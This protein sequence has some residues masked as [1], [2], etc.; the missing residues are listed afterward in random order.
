MV[1]VLDASLLAGLVLATQSVGLTAET[2]SIVIDGT[3]DLESSFIANSTLSDGESYQLDFDIDLNVLTSRS[4]VDMEFSTS[5]GSIMFD[6][7]YSLE[8]A[9]PD[10]VGRDVFELNMS[11]QSGD[12]IFELFADIPVLVDPLVRNFTF[13]DQGS[14][15][16]SGSAFT[17]GGIDTPLGMCKPSAPLFCG[18]NFDSSSATIMIQP[19]FSDAVTPV[20]LPA[21]FWLLAAGVGLLGASRSRSSS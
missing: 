19:T 6:A 3:V 11:G 7:F 15:F 18:I 21:A 13:D 4:D 14:S 10:A 16:F 1:R 20:P 2:V 8:T 5:G 9:S 17:F 12:V